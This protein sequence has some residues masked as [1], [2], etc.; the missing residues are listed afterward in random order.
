MTLLHIGYELTV[1]PEMHQMCEYEFP[2]RQGFRKLSSD[3]QTR[4]RC[5][6][7]GQKRRSCNVRRVKVGLNWLALAVGSALLRT[8]IDPTAAALHRVAWSRLI[9][10]CASA[11][12]GRRS[13]PSLPRPPWPDRCV[14]LCRNHLFGDTVAVRRRTKLQQLCVFSVLHR[15]RGDMR[16]LT[17]SLINIT[18]NN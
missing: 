10:V 5:F 14:Q 7:G 9:G 1:F 11:S 4:P 2:I 13:G 18:N 17:N 12:A 15:R 8:F 3:R 6:A 16:Q